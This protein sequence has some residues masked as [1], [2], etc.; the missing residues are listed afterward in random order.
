MNII[1]LEIDSQYHLLRS[2]KQMFTLH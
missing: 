1:L 2:F